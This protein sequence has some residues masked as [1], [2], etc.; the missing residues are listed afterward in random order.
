MITITTMGESRGVERKDVVNE[1]S[2]E[3][4]EHETD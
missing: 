2:N 4:V 3:E 1:D